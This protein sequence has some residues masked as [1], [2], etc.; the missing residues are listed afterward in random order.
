MREFTETLLKT[1]GDSGPI[2]VYS[3]FEETRLRE[4]ATRFTDL[5][6]DLQQ[7]MGR[8]VD[9]LPL[10]REHY[11]HPDMRGSW[12]VK[13]VL[14]TLAPELSYSDLGEVQDGTA[15][16]SAYLELIDKGTPEARREL[17]ARDMR[18]YC[19]MDTWAIERMRNC[20]ADVF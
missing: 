15:A 16:Q 9:L 3:S 6:D 18:R 10:M 1:L 17:L 19:E 12:S 20:I 2:L 5:E 7:V 8:L 13:A 4:L 11:Y 14:P